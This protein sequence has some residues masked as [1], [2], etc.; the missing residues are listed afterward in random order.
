M[1]LNIIMDDII[2][3]FYNE[4]KSIINKEETV[5]IIH[6][7]KKELLEDNYMLYIADTDVITKLFI[8]FLFYYNLLLDDN[9][10]TNK[11]FHCGIDYEFNTIKVR[12]I[13]LMQMN[14]TINNQKYLWIID[15]KKYDKKKTDIIND[16][17]LLNDKVYKV[18][19][20]SESLD[21]PYMYDILFES[22]KDKILKF[23]KKLIDTRFLCEYVRKSTGI[24][25]KCSIYDALLYFGTITQEKYDEL[26]LMNEAMG[27]I[28]DVMW[29]INK[30]GSFH[31]KY[32]LYDVLKL[33]LLL[34]DIYKK[35]LETTP[36]YIRT[37]YYINKIIRFVILER[38]KVTNILEF[39]KGVVNPMNNYIVEINNKKSTLIDLF[40]KITENCIVKEDNDD[41]YISFIESISY[42]KGTFNFLL[43]Y[44][45]FYVISKKYKIYKNKNDLMENE[46]KIKLLYEELE[47]IGF[48]RIIKLLKIFEEYIKK[49]I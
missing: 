47:N 38:K 17:L 8:M 25:G 12:Q 36:S 6:Y 26:I 5:K 37:Y 45:V 35:I 32:A 27:P 41:I 11:K 49:I 21:I 44:V 13:A 33:V 20:G 18:L 10:N 30:M 42:V 7:Y 2:I 28:Q 29:E 46:I 19:H 22:D 14:F 23:T 4:P 39:V 43:K 24:T 40:N 34:E 48:E 15:P 1:L 31:I 3:N 16:L 9:K